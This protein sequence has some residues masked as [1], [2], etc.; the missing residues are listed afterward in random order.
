M[1]SILPFALLVML[2]LPSVAEQ[3]ARSVTVSA[4]G[5]VEAVPDT[6]QLTV[7]IREV[8][9]DLAGVQTRLDKRARQIVG[10]AKR[11]KIA[12]EDLDNSR[13]RAWQE[14]EWRQNKRHYIGEAM[15]RDLVITLRDVD[16]Y[17]ELV[18]ALSKLEVDTIAPP[19]LSHSREDE[20]QIEALRNAMAVGARKARAL[21][22]EASSKLG[23]VLKVREVTGG[24]GGPQPMM[25]A[26]AAE[27]RATGAPQFSLAPREISVDLQI[28]YALE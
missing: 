11:L 17:G 21:A 15:Q 14:Y 5:S 2:S 16:R 12:D 4:T 1:R 22:E 25:M 24:S 23:P 26:A 3:A 18:L 7:S 27:S 9:P 19:R 10:A 6:L 20:L 13:F 28:S 8:G